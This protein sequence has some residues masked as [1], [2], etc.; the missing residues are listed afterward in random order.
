MTTDDPVIQLRDE[1]RDLFALLDIDTRV[2]TTEGTR[3]SIVVS[4]LPL[5]DAR[6]L[7]GALDASDATRVRPL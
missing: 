1:L 5:S 2:V 4:P 3:R 6:K 7:V